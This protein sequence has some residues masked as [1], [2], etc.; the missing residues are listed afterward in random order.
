[1]DIKRSTIEAYRDAWRRK[2]GSI[3]DVVKQAQVDT[4]AP[5]AAIVARLKASLTTDDRITQCERWYA[6]TGRF[7]STAGCS[8]CPARQAC[9]IHGVFRYS[10]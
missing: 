10:P 1:M 5:L 9:Q 8:T 3:L 4:G 2:D 6:D 7:P